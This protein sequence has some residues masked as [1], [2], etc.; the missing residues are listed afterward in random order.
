MGID[1]SNFQR[2][3]AYLNE[4][5]AE[6][7]YALQFG[8]YAD[9]NPGQGKMVKC[10]LCGRRRREVPLT[11]CCN[12]SHAT[13]QRAYSKEKGFHQVN[14]QK[15]NAE[16]GVWEDAPRVNEGMMG[17]AFFKRFTHKRHSNKF[18]KR[19]HDLILQ[20][21]GTVYEDENATKESRAKAEEFRNI[22]QLYLE[23]LV[24]F[25]EPKNLVPLQS[26]PNFAE[27]VLRAER[28]N[29]ANRKRKQQ[30]LSRR[31]NRRTA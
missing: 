8:S 23:G 25:H 27:R 1:L 29:A 20:M 26:I 13:T 4:I 18:R 30:K 16:K 28:Q 6:G 24:G 12:T 11:P 9:R 5:T 2:D 22:T 14:S 3:A 31:I 10:P 17:K 21:T 19:L 15:W 7:I